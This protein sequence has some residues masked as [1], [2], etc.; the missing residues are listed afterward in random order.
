MGGT[1]D[2]EQ[3]G[4]QSIGCYAYFVTLS[5]D[6]DLRFSRSNFENAASQEWEGRL[7]WNQKDESQ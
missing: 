5:F 6:L 1:V 7:A 4:Y 2:N 3:K